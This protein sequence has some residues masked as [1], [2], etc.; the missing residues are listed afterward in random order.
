VP[1]EVVRLRR[2]RTQQPVDGCGPGREQQQAADARQEP[3]SR[4]RVDDR[5][6]EAELRQERAP[7]RRGLR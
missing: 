2:V 4:G 1:A 5:V 7:S 3:A 6:A